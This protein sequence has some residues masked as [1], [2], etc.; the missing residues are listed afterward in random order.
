MDGEQTKDET[1]KDA[2]ASH[3]HTH[4][5]THTTYLFWVLSLFPHKFERA[6]VHCPFAT[7]YIK[8]SLQDSFNEAPFAN[9]RHGTGANHHGLA[10]PIQAVGQSSIVRQV[11]NVTH[12]NLFQ[13]SAGHGL[14]ENFGALVGSHQGLGVKVGIVLECLK[15]ESTSFPT[16]TRDQHLGGIGR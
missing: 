2:R 6:K 1:K 14:A 10:T 9:G 3:T 15:D 11:C 12:D 16:R 8:G 5:H 7:D 13:S 4:T